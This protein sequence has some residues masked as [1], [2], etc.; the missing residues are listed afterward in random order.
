MLFALTYI[1]VL[2]APGFL[3]SRLLKVEKQLLL[4]SISFSLFYFV[5]VLLFSFAF[6]LSINNFFISY[7]AGLA[8][9]VLFSKFSKAAAI[10]VN[11]LKFCGFLIVLTTGFLYMSI[12]GFYD[13]LPSDVYIHL[14]FFKLVSNQLLTN[15]FEAAEG[16]NLVSR[17]NYYWYYIPALISYLNQTDFL[18]HLKI[19]STINV[20]VLLACI[21]EFS[22]WLYKSQIKNRQHLL[23]TALLSTLFFALHFGISVFAYIRYYAIA[24][25]ILNYCIYLTSIVCLINYY[26]GRSD[27]ARFS[28]ISFALFFTAFAIHAQESLFIGIIYCVVS[29]IIFINK[30]H[31][32]I[33]RRSARGEIKYVDSVFLIF[34]AMAAVLLAVYFLITHNLELS[35]IHSTKVVPLN[36]LINY[37]SDLFIL[38]PYQQFYTVLTHWGFFV[39]VVYVLLYRRLFRDQPVLLAGML[40]PLITVFNPY[41][42]DMFLRIASANVLWR[43]L[44]MMPLYLVAARIVTGLCLQTRQAIHKMV[45]NYVLASMVFI[46]LLPVNT[47]AFNLPYSRIYSLSAVPDQARPVHWQDMLDFLVTLPEKEIVISDPV[48]GYMISALTKHQNR[49]H[50]F[51][52]HRMIDPYEFDDYSNHPLKKYSGNILILNQRTGTSTTIAQIARHWNPNNLNLTEFYSQSLIDHIHAEPA[53]FKLLWQASRIKIY[54]IDYSEISD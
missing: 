32:K 5:S 6:S 35:Q 30:I 37:G 22:H 8:G 42:N 12:V 25:T 7:C 36:S 49:R 38:N 4:F 21:Y 13:E 47:S 15:Q 34:P 29:A 31:Q 51:Y 11:K 1:F 41:F 48:T 40:I 53:H 9:I 24:P 18:N 45:M 26:Q 3:I 19:Y 16:I 44:Y 33:H 20:T 2:I 14:E 52:Y 46:L 43:F 50:K 17:S 28:F 27:F 10:S 23:L 54:R 39:A